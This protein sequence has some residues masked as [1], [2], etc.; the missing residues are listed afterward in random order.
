MLHNNRGSMLLS[1]V[2]IIVVFSVIIAV[3]I[4]IL[5][6]TDQVKLSATYSTQAEAIARGGAE[7]VLGTLFQPGHGNAYKSVLWQGSKPSSKT[8]I[9]NNFC[10]THAGHLLCSKDF[11]VYT[12][13]QLESVVIDVAD[14]SADKENLKQSTVQYVYFITATAS[15]NVP[16]TDTVMMTNADHANTYKITRTVEVSAVDLAWLDSLKVQ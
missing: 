6:G 12:G 1:A 10:A 13:C 8:I 2:F 4:K 16:F 15:C 11:L 9:D 3:M 14:A 7:F 5:M